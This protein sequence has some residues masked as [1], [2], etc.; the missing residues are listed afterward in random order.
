MMF[1]VGGLWLA[2]VAALLVMWRVVLAASGR[3]PIDLL[4]FE[5]WL[6]RGVSDHWWRMLLL[7]SGAALVWAAGFAAWGWDVMSCSRGV[8]IATSFGRRS[9]SVSRGCWFSLW[10]GSCST[11][12]RRQ[13]ACFR[14]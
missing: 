8:T 7:G 6:K 9:G 10:S 3:E 5:A 1:A 12:G 4:R 14:S 13:A 2:G 11:I